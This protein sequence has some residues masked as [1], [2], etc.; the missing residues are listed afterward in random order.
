MRREVKVYKV[1]ACIPNALV[2]LCD[3][4]SGGQS[5]PYRTIGACLRRAADENI[6]IL[7]RRVSEG[8]ALLSSIPRLRVGFFR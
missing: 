4:A 8:I 2:V 6:P 1:Q 5:P 3:D 7:T